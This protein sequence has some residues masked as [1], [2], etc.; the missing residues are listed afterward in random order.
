M[1][2]ESAT[3][4]LTKVRTL[5]SEPATQ[6]NWNIQCK[7]KGHSGWVWAVAFSP[8]GNQIASASADKTIKLWDSTTGAMR[9]MFK[10]HS[11]DVWA[12]AFSPDGNQIVSASS[13]G[14]VRLWDSATEAAVPAKKRTLTKHLKELF[15]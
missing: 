4:V 12:V 7:L 3:P 6:K 5:T 11:S 2:A 1:L 13:D 9:N 15:R 14:T 8:D 10:G